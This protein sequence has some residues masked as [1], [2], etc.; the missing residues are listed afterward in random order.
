MNR[1]DPAPAR[2]L[3]IAELLF[4]RILEGFGNKEIADA[5]R[6]SPSSVSRDMELLRQAGWARKMDNGRWA[7]T[8]KPAALV[9]TYTLYMAARTAQQELFMN[10]VTTGAQ[11]LVEEYYG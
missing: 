3:R 11:H 7:L 1:P 10:R 8:E 4:T 6:V 2:I 5:L 9:H